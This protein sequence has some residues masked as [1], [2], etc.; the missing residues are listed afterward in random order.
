MEVLLLRVMKICAVHEQ[1]LLP[2][3]DD[4]SPAAVGL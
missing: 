1:K 4:Q 3:A 2:M